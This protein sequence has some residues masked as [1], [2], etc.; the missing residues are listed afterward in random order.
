[1]LPRC[2]RAE[3]VT[4]HSD[5]NSSLGGHRGIFIQNLPV[6]FFF[7]PKRIFYLFLGPLY[8]PPTSS[9]KKTV[10]LHS[11]PNSWPYWLRGIFVQNLLKVL[12]IFFLNI[13]QFVSRTSIYSTFKFSCKNGDI[14]FMSKFLTRQTKGHFRTKFTLDFFFF[15]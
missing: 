12:F 6:G 4:L 11:G 13:F 3:T 14:A 15:S 2:F 9:R 1:M 7:P 10:A 8:M 5:P